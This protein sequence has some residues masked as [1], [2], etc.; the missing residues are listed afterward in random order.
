M[1]SSHATLTCLPSAEVCAGPMHMLEGMLFSNMR[2]ILD[3]LLNEI[4][5]TI[6]LAE[7]LSIYTPIYISICLVLNPQTRVIVLGVYGSP[8]I[9]TAWEYDRPAFIINYL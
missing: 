5:N 4:S 3:Q 9:I 8:G 2:V 6:D 7:L 1:W